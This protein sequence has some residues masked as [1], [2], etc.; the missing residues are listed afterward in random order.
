MVSFVRN[1]NIHVIDI[2]T[3]RERPLTL[4]SNPK[5]FNG[6]L[7]WVYQEELYGRGNFKGYWWSPDSTKIV[8]LQLNDHPVAE[9]T[10][11]DQIPHFP[12]VETTPYPKA[13]DQNP[14]VK[15]GVVSASGDTTQWVD[16]F[17][18]AGVE[19][20]IVRVSWTPD[21]QKVVYEVQNREQTWL[22]LNYADPA[23]GKPET[24]LRETSKAW[25]DVDNVE[26]PIWL[27]DGT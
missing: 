12:D 20:L 10:I 23:S 24:I 4:D 3:R 17:K 1:Y 25:V 21:S 15:L 2:A 13:G 19:P 5:L 18:Y 26:L 7:D 8:Y 16:M 9:F 14:T 11:V 27:K 6:R 22:D